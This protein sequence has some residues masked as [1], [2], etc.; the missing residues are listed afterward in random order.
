MAEGRTL[1]H[2]VSIMKNIWQKS[3][4]TDDISSLW[5]KITFM[6]LSST[7]R[8]ILEKKKYK[9]YFHSAFI[10]CSVTHFLQV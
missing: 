2:L 5:P 3:K 10:G 7:E 1:K 4:G 6:P 9:G 8:D